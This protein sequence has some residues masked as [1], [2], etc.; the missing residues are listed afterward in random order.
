M[1]ETAKIQDIQTMPHISSNNV[2]DNYSNSSEIEENMDDEFSEQEA[3]TDSD[4]D[5]KLTMK[6]SFYQI[7]YFFSKS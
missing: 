1:E 7:K 5:F 2:L 3:S 6:C 4:D